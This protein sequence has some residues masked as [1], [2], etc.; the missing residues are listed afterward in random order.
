MGR[1]AAFLGGAF[2]LLLFPYVRWAKL[3]FE[4][5]VF[6]PQTPM[7]RTSGRYAEEWLFLRLASGS[8]PRGATYGVRA[9]D[10]KQEMSLHMMSLGLLPA[11]RPIPAS[12]WDR[13]LEPSGERP[14]FLLVF[15]C[16]RPPGEGYRLVQG[17]LGSCVYAREGPP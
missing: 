8:V 1:L 16:E 9:A 4:Q 14:D 17:V 2:L 15:R 12:Y 10:L 3:P 13:P 5:R 6:V 11:S 7:D